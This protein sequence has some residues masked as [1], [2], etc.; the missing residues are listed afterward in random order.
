VLAP[1]QIAEQAIG[2]VGDGG[3]GG[4]FLECHR[5]YGP[6]SNIGLN[7]PCRLPSTRPTGPIETANPASGAAE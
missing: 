4:G 5:E 1:R 3:L 6:S 7:W 2:T